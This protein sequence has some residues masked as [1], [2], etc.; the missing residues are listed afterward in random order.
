MNYGHLLDKSTLIE[1]V[2]VIFVMNLK[3]FFVGITYMDC[4]NQVLPVTNWNQRNV[5]WVP[6]NHSLELNQIL[7]HLSII[8]MNVKRFSACLWGRLILF[9]F[10][11]GLSQNISIKY[12]GFTMK[13]IIYHFLLLRH[14]F[15]FRFL[16]T[17]IYNLWYLSDFFFLSTLIRHLSHFRFLLTLLF[18]ILRIFRRIVVIVLDLSIRNLVLCTKYII[19]NLL[20]KMNKNLFGPLW[21]CI[22][23][24]FCPYKLLKDLYSLLTYGW[25]EFLRS[26]I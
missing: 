23:R 20:I 18:S 22:I 21:C 12:I 25:L 6:L 24:L 4:C 9:L 13:N 15:Y 1:L 5:F 2:A 19:W 17:L 11:S 3:L 14:L 26:L 8:C 16:P 7:H 10:R